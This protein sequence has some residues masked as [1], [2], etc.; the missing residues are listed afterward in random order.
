MPRCCEDHSLLMLQNH[1]AVIAVS[2]AHKIDLKLGSTMVS[3]AVRALQYTMYCS[4]NQPARPQVQRHI[5]IV[6]RDWHALRATD[7]LLTDTS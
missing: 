5:A 3:C 4:R 1:M 7:R 6:I 2:V